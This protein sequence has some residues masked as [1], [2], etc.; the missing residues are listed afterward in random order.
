M[1]GKVALLAA[2]LLTATAAILGGCGE[3]DAAKADKQPR[4]EGG[5]IRVLNTTDQPVAILFGRRRLGD[6]IDPG[7]A[8]LFQKEVPGNNAFVIGAPGAMPM[9]T[10]AEKQVELKSGTTTT[11]VLR[12]SGNEWS[13]VTIENEPR[14]ADQGSPTVTLVS[15]DPA[16]PVDV[17][18][19]GQGQKIELGRAEGFGI[20]ET[21]P[22][23]PGMY[24]LVVDGKPVGQEFEI[25][26]EVAY[27]AFVFMMKG[28]VSGSV[29]R[30]T[31]AITIQGIEGAAGA[32]G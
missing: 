19:E 3:G 16:S 28:A 5:H 7:D 15:L 29:H 27:S 14:F 2:A 31:P 24:R 10:L 11:Y 20:R 13:V 26:E 1:K 8:S 23:P 18:L 21:K 32:G 25:R 9:Q 17:A 12:K 30:N 4:R 22:V 6:Q